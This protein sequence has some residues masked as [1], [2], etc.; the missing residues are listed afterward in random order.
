MLNY[1]EEMK[2]NST[3][4]WISILT[5]ILY[6]VYITSSLGII[7][8]L[9]S[10]AGALIAAAFTNS[11]EIVTVAVVILGI[12][13]V[14]ATRM[15]STRMLCAGGKEAF[16]TDGTPTEILDVVDSMT[17]QKYGAG[18]TITPSYTGIVSSMTEGF[19]DAPNATDAAPGLPAPPASTPAATKDDSSVKA[20][21]IQ[22]AV[23][24][25]LNAAT[26]AT[27]LYVQEPMTRGQRRRARGKEKTQKDRGLDSPAN[28][29]SHQVSVFVL[30]Y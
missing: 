13:Y 4:Y 18:R 30:L 26:A 25:A 9:L 3:T 22:K 7:G 27:S 6:L 1:V 19:A 11:I 20:E 21:Q 16:T 17:K 28:P 5:L 15:V 8:I 12:S 10:L 23:K 2:F 24:T 14:F 29:A